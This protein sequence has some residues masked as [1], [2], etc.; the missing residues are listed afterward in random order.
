[1]LL[2]NNAI[3]SQTHDELKPIFQQSLKE[4]LSS[5]IRMWT[6]IGFSVAG[7]SGNGT[8]EIINHEYSW[9][10]KVDILQR[11]LLNNIGEGFTYSIIFDELDDGY[12][13]LSFRNEYNDLLTSLFRA[14]AE[15]KQTFRD[16]LS[17]VQPVILLRDDIYKQ[18]DDTGTRKWDDWIVELDWNTLEMMKMLAHRVSVSCGLNYTIDSN[19]L[20][21]LI[22]KLDPYKGAYYDSREKCN[23]LHYI[24]IRTLNRPRDIITWFIEIATNCVSYSNTLINFKNVVSVEK[25]VSEK[26]QKEFEN[27]LLGYMKIKDPKLP[28]DLLRVFANNTFTFEGFEVYYEYFQLGNILNINAIEF[29]RH[30]FEFSVIGFRGNDG[31]PIFKHNNP[32]TY[33]DH[34]KN[35]LVAVCLLSA[36][37][38]SSDFKQVSRNINALTEKVS[39]YEPNLFRDKYVT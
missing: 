38:I 13:D 26:M 27:E 19:I 17:F 31:K 29:L 15:I 16:C 33:F 7:L 37:G 6:G 39:F 22:S 36:L 2:E 25:K 5:N 24:S 11:Y 34:K 28:F 1:M 18:L 21:A 14:V 35:I 32:L 8:C 30:L 9:S 23:L 12:A 10:E 3:N 20:F 4:T